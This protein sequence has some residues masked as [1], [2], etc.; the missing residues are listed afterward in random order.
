MVL[1]SV[2]KTNQISEKGPLIVEVEGIAIGI[3]KIRGKYYAYNNECP[4]QGGPI[5]EGMMFGDVVCDVSPKGNRLGEHFSKDKTIIVCPWHGVPYDVE[6]GICRADER[7][8][9][10]SHK[11][12]VD[13]DDIKIQI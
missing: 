9:L 2:A 11:V 8:K 6:T 5:N 1:H 7:L 12:V 13:G 3:Y 10:F 4:H